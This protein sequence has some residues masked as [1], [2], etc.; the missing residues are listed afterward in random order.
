MYFINLCQKCLT[1]FIFI[2]Y[3]SE[4]ESWHI[5]WVSTFS[6]FNLICIEA[7]YGPN[8]KRSGRWNCFKFQRMDFLLWLWHSPIAKYM[9]KMGFAGV[10]QPVNSTILGPNNFFVAF[11]HQ[12]FW[13]LKIVPSTFESKASKEEISKARRNDIKGFTVLEYNQM[14][15]LIY[16]NLFLWSFLIKCYIIVEIICSHTQWMQLHL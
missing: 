11:K 1:Y 12:F 16:R 13:L 15:Q 7:N 10:W 3:D 4:I 2:S 14:F 8:C 6:S 5:Y 9:V